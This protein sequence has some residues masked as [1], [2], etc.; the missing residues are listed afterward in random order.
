VRRENWS[1]KEVTVLFKSSRRESAVEEVEDVS[2]GRSFCAGAFES[3]V[4]VGVVDDNVV[5]GGEVIDFSGG[6]TEIEEV[7]GGAGAEAEFRRFAAGWA[8]PR[9]LFLLREELP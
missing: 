7:A 2:A 8:L 9:S 3:S 1:K 6:G 4:A 5:P